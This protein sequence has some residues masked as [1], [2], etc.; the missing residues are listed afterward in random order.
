MDFLADHVHHSSLHRVST[1][2]KRSP[3][4]KLAK[5]ARM[6]GGSGGYYFVSF[7]I[8]YLG[9]KTSSIM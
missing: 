1:L 4:N 5:L 6:A 9:I 2:T 7:F 3:I 8:C